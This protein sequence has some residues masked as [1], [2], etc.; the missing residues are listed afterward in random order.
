MPK[1]RLGR[2]LLGQL[3]N[4]VKKDEEGA[5]S[6]QQRAV[7]DLVVIC[8]ILTG[9]VLLIVSLLPEKQYVCCEVG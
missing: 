8:V 4:L 7:A 6:G 2:R 1:S 5:G 9:E 3:G